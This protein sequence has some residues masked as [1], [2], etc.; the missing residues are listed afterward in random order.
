MKKDRI[1][2][3]VLAA[4]M[5]A[6]LLAGCSSNGKPGTA[7]QAQSVSEQQ[8]E[9]PSAPVADETDASEA[10]AMSAEKTEETGSSMESPESELQLEEVSLPLFE[11][12]RT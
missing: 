6:S 9:A 7:A 11:E 2:S 5:S 10:E 8:A 4:A 12:T 3:F 1:L